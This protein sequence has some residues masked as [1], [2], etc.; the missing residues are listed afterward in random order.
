M[1]MVNLASKLRTR[2]I[3]ELRFSLSTLTNSDSPTQISHYNDVGSINILYKSA[4]CDLR[5]D[6][7]VLL[8]SFVSQQCLAF[9]HTACKWVPPPLQSLRR[10]RGRATS[11]MTLCPPF[12]VETPSWPPLTRGVA[13]KAS[14][15]L[16]IPRPTSF[17]PG[18]QCAKFFR[19]DNKDI[20]ALERRTSASGPTPHLVLPLRSSDPKIRICSHAQDLPL[21]YDPPIHPPVLV[22]KIR[23]LRLLPS[24]I[25]TPAHEIVAPSGEMDI[26]ASPCALN[27]LPSR[28]KFAQRSPHSTQK[29]QGRILEVSMCRSSFSVWTFSL[30]LLHLDGAA[31]PHPTY[32]PLGDDFGDG[33]QELLFDIPSRYALVTTPLNRARG[34]PPGDLTLGWAPGF[35]TSQSVRTLAPR[36]RGCSH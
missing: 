17:P 26:T 36:D 1:D 30:L 35:N 31:C 5:Q 2:R 23:T 4:T 6:A 24:S 7:S 18:C 16:L 15:K 29:R 20:M 3:Q 12:T 33:D 25:A 9:D 21:I 28:D 27:H 13:L 34:H 22:R 10:Q 14:I 8:L 32:L 19:G 11:G